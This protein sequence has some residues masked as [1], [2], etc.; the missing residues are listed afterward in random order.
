MPN[1]DLATLALKAT[2]PKN[3]IMVDDKGLPSVMVYIPKFKISDVIT[4]GSA[5]THP[6]FIVNG[7]EVPGIYISKYQN[8]LGSNGRAYSLPGEDPKASITFDSAK[9]AC[10]LKGPG[11]HLMTKAEWAAI[12]LWCRKNNLM[13]KGNNDYGKDASEGTR[14]A[15][16]TY[17]DA[18]NTFR[19]ATGTGPKTWSHNGDFDG[20]WD[21]NGNVYEW[22][23]G[24]RT[25]N[26]EIQVIQNNNAAA[27]V[28]QSATS[29]LWR[30]ILEDGS[31]TDPGTAN[32]L[33][34]DYLTTPAAN[35]AFRLNKV[36]E[37]PQ[38]DDTPYGSISFA[39]LT[40]AA[41]VTVPEILKALSIFP[42]DTGDHGGDTVY[43]RN[44]GERLLFCGGSWY[45]GSA[46]GV[47]C[48]NGGSPRSHSYT[49]LGFRSAFVAL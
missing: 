24:Y 49:N 44:N 1:F 18:T 27:A 11:W 25:N 20:I 29:T 40:A 45:L 17:Y 4:G 21:L 10:E 36:I 34:W 26:G 13:P 39:S 8:V 15:I 48:G 46:A 41:G 33:K 47:F 5:N 30:A 2:F 37:Y 43:M 9:Q 32:T 38:A 31:L 28:D 19:V 6:A 42:A 35:A 16:P 14:V 23:G 22:V 7:V 3:V 12:A